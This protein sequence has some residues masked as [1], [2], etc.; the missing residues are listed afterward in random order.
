MRALFWRRLVASDSPLSLAG[1]TYERAALE[2]WLKRSRTCPLTRCVLADP[3]VVP[4]WALR[5]AMD[6]WIFSSGLMPL[7]PPSNPSLHPARKLSTD[8]AGL[9]GPLVL[10]AFS[11]GGALLALAT[12]RLL[13][14]PFMVSVLVWLIL[15]FALSN[16]TGR[17]DPL[18]RWRHG[19]LRWLNAS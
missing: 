15:S 6:D 16:N 4:N 17:G 2:A 9:R 11:V 3:A 7:R 14:E 19:T 5:A 12:R 8:P 10:A 13:Q 18:Q 1:H